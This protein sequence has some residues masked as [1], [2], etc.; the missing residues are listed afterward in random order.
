V[1]K[2]L[3]DA[4]GISFP[5]FMRRTVL[6]PANMTRSTYAQPIPSTLAASA[7]AGHYPVE[8]A[9][10]GRWHVYPEMAAAGLWTT[11][12]DLARF[13][14]AIQASYLGRSS[15]L[16]A[17]RTT[18]QMLT[19]QKAHDGLGAFL[20]DSGRGRKFFHGGRNE[21]FDGLLFATVSTGQGVVVMINANDNSGMINRIEAFVA[22][23]YKW[24]GEAAYEPPAPVATPAVTLDSYAGRYELADNQPIALVVD[25]TRL[26]TTSDGLPDQLF[27]PVGPGRFASVDR[28]AQFVVQTDTSGLV[29]GLRWTENGSDRTV[30]RIGPLGRTLA[31]SADPDPAFTTRV[32]AVVRAME[33]GDGVALTA[34]GLLTEQARHDFADIGKWSEVAGQRGLSYLARES[35]V[36]RGIKRHAGTVDMIAYYSMVTDA[37]RRTLLV[38][39]TRDGKVSDFDVVND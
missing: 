25:G 33:Q 17:P 34:P 28:P 7:A 8:R 23:K 5:E 13:A 9:V 22:R 10:T 12:T 16:L 11:P 39:L 38:Y 37:G 24:P 4:T 35:V 32:E 19:E 27:V 14:I 2:M 18:R 31:R 3:L 6:G 1:Q 20:T 15:R 29:T 26:A 21:G 36:G 30:P